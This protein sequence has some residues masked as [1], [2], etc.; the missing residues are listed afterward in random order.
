MAKKLVKRAKSGLSKKPPQ[1][2]KEVGLTEKDMKKRR[3]TEETPPGAV[4][5]LPV[6]AVPKGV[7][8]S[9]SIPKELLP[10]ITVRTDAE[11]GAME[12]EELGPLMTEVEQKLAKK[13]EEYQA[14]AHYGNVL[15]QRFNEINARWNNVFKDII[16][17]D[18][19]K[20]GKQGKWR[21]TLT[22]RSDG[23][24]SPLQGARISVSHSFRF[25]SQENPP[26]SWKAA[27]DRAMGNALTN[28]KD[29]IEQERLGQAEPIV[30][31][32]P[33][34][35]KFVNKDELP[36]EL[37]TYIDKHQKS[38][39][40]KLA[41]LAEEQGLSPESEQGPNSVAKHASA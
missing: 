31:T 17:P 26:W 5:E 28:L 7:L 19:G 23:L 1:K 24:Q 22:P 39:E 30:S 35:V 27:K 25:A 20:S 37:I 14:L 29:R 32:I 6:V 18:A 3:A 15:R 16:E 38:Y 40:A 21:P 2:R 41:K 10:D 8:Q 13:R 9:S 12:A 33:E 11:I 34:I 36:P 4:E